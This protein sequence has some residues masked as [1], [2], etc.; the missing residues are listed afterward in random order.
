M[1]ISAR[2]EFRRTGLFASVV[3]HTRPLERA[4]EAISINAQYAE[5][6]GKMVGM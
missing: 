5:D 3:T 2:K 4:A 1:S 6:V